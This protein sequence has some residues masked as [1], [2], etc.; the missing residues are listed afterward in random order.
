MYPDDYGFGYFYL[1][2]EVIDNGFSILN[3]GESFK[4]EQGAEL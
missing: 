4:K 3:N 2:V 1:R